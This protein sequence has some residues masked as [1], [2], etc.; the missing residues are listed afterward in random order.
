M[1]KLAMLALPLAITAFAQSAH[2]QAP[3]EL[4]YFE[5]A[6]YTRLGWRRLCVYGVWFGVGLTSSA[7]L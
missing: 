2:S 7:S 3:L 6:R 1:R 4:L 5:H